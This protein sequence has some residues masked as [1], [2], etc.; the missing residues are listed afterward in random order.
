MS[1]LD[2]ARADNQSILEMD[3]DVITLTAPASDGGTVY[4]DVP[5]RFIRRGATRDVEGFMAVGEES[6]VSIAIASLA[7]A[8]IIDPEA[9]KEKGW[10]VTSGA[11]AYRID[12][13]PIDYANGVVTAFL[14]KGA[15]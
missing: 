3:G 4:P 5:C 1:L 15:A 13:C 9:L 2:L 8:G 12:V 10:A 6:V 7:A 14:K 11:Q